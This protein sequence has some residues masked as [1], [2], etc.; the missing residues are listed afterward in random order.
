MQYAGGRVGGGRAGRAYPFAFEQFSAM[1]VCGGVKDWE[2]LIDAKKTVS[3]SHCLWTMGMKKERAH[4]WAHGNQLRDQQHIHVVI[5]LL[6]LKS[7]RLL[8]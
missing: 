3:H 7:S 1:R 6:D 4:A 2:A 5:I 8:G